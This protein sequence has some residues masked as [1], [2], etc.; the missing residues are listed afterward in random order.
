MAETERQDKRPACGWPLPRTDDKGKQIGTKDCGSEERVYNVMGK[1]LYTGQKRETPVCEKH[2][3]D[4]W[5]K[6]DVDSAQPVN[7][8]FSRGDG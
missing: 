8:L 6:W 1:G 4:A 2:L 3:P 7:P 5:K